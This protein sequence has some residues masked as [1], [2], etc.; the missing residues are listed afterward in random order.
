[1]KK[2]LN[3]FLKCNLCNWEWRARITKPK[4]CPRCKRYEWEKNKGNINDINKRVE[5][6]D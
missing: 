1:M 6:N 4:V 2:S 5:E 3:E